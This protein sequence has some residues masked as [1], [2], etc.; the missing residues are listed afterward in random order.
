MAPALRVQIRKQVIGYE[1]SMARATYWILL[2]ATALVQ[3]HRIAGKWNNCTKSMSC[4]L[5]RMPLGELNGLL[6]LDTMYSKAS[7]IHELTERSAEQMLFTGIR[8]SCPGAITKWTFL[9][10]ETEDGESYPELQVWR[11]DDG[12][13]V[14]RRKNSSTA[15]NGQL[16]SPWIYELLIQPPLTFEA[17]DILGVYQ[18]N[19]TNS[20]LVSQYQ[21]GGGRGKTLRLVTS[22]PVDVVNTEDLDILDN[23]RLHPL[24]ALE[25]TGEYVLSITL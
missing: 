5:S 20:K 8:F 7:L 3:L 13:T 15:A 19:A 17:G 23:L 12:E 18:P 9:A 10:R 11:S 2:A 6:D 14:Y 1:S 21:E 4:R 24:L 22:G 16:R 25:L